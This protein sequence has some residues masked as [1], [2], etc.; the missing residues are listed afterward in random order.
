MHTSNGWRLKVLVAAPAIALSAVAAW[1]TRV[2]FTTTHRPNVNHALLGAI[3][4]H[5]SMSALAALD[6]GADPNLRDED[7]S[8]AS[9]I[10]DRIASYFRLPHGSESYGASAL[11][12]SLEDAYGTEDRRPT[13]NVRA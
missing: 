6:A 2:G 7:P 5:D 1:A 8:A 9:S 10:W 4:H 3:R 13:A 12:L 11:T